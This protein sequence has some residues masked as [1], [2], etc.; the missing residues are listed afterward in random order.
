MTR[1]I[2]VL[3]KDIEKWINFNVRVNFKMGRIYQEEQ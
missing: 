3:A 2:R 1:D